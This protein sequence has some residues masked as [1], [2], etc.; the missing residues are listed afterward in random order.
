VEEVLPEALAGDDPI[1]IED[2]SNGGLRG[3]V[4]GNLYAVRGWRG[5]AG[6]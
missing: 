5:L 2:L 6:E 4:D 3:R 1:P